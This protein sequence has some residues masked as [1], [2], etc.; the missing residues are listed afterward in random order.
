[1]PSDKSSDILAEAFAR[2]SR[3]SR[4]FIFCLVGIIALGSMKF[5]LDHREQQAREDEQLQNADQKETAD[6]IVALLKLGNERL[7]AKAILER[8]AIFG[9]SK[10]QVRQ[11]KG[12]PEVYLDGR[13]IPDEVRSKGIV[14][15]WDYGN[16]YG[17]SDRVYFDLN[18]AVIFSTDMKR[19]QEGK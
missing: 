15:I 4:W 7:I 17:P 5:Y 18:G 6:E 9:M 3:G 11:A 16:A 2:P 8:K 1:M 14:E 13:Q 19:I 10:Y 12:A